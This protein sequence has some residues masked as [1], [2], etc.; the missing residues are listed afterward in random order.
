MRVDTAALDRVFHP[1]TVVVIGDKKSSNYMFLTSL[2]SFSGK[3]YSVQIDPEEIPGIEAMG[4]TNFKSLADV[5]DPVD[6]AIVAVPRAVSP[7][8][9]ADC[10]QNKVGGATL[11]TSGFAETATPEGIETQERLFTMAEAAGMVLIGPNCM[12]V[13]NP[14]LGLC[15]LPGQPV[16]QG[17]NVGFISQSGS[18]AGGFASVA[19]ESGL[20]VSKMVSFGNGIVLENADYLEYLAQDSQTQVIAMYVEGLKDGRRFFNLLK[21]TT[22]RKPVVIWKGGQTQEGQRAT[23][24]HTASLAESM[25]IWEAVVKQT[26]AILVHSLDEAVDTVKGLL[27]LPPI[28]GT[29]CGLTGGAGGQSVSITDAFAKAGMSVPALSPDSYEKLEAFFKLIGASFR[30]PIDMGVNRRDIDTIFDVLAQDPVIDVIV[31]QLGVTRGDR[32]RQ[33]R[34]TPIDSFLRMKGRTAK[35]LVAIP[36]S[37]TPYKDGEALREVQDK[38]QEAG[39]PCFPSY[40]RAGRALRNVVE[41]HRFRRA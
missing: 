27:F 31:M 1:K 33:Q 7:R 14:T 20:Q 22:P 3:V 40:E 29:G 16:Y 32:G 38:L 15:F 18:H 5:P 24:S 9:V 41:F 34:E 39:V 6:Y 35:P 37:T 2:R 23:S 28:T 4:I 19:F 26:G 25:A 30:N 10:I 13:Y 12:G 8:I 36:Y 21:A 11:F 17:G